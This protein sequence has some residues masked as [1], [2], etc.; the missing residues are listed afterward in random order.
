M[1]TTRV[2]A[3]V[4]VLTSLV[5]AVSLGGPALAQ[6]ADL[7][8]APDT[9]AQDKALVG[10]LNHRIHDSRIGSDFAMRVIDAETGR[11]IYAHDADNPQRAASNTKLV[12]AV[13]ALATA[14]P[15]KALTT[16]ARLAA[17]GKDVILQGGGDP[18]LSPSQIY[19]L[20]D[21]TAAKLKRG[22]K[23]VVHLDLD[24]FYKMRRG[25][26]WTPGYSN[27]LLAGVQA[28]A[29]YG[30]HPHYPAKVVASAFISRLRAK[31]INAVLGRT[32]SAVPKARVLAK[33]KGHTVA[34]SVAVMLS[35]SESNIAEVL[36]RQAAVAAGH[37]GSWNGGIATT[38]EVMKSLGVSMD[39]V[40]I[41]DGSGLSRKDHLT[42]R[43]LTEMLRAAKVLQGLRFKAMF[44]RYAMPIAGQTGTL[45]TPYGRYD[46]YP[47]RCAAGRV[48]AKT[49]TLYD[50]I[51]LSGVSKTVS[52]RTL[53]FSMIIN[54]RPSQYEKLANRRALDGLAATITG[55][56]K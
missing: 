22:S 31:G 35:R 5:L 55:C 36:F 18:L 24:L 42:P 56:W 13:T 54:S 52:G 49:G 17:N 40:A 8:T 25:P 3:G 38:K 33:T 7:P 19:S 30:Q 23:V 28:L 44:A 39:N 50:A 41:Y 48:Q 27:Y 51:A 37:R 26:G 4:A 46:T 16:Y 45:A 34:Q 9:A 20:A 43:F 6:P 29:F 14:G 32:E 10:L 15:N 21:R 2:R 47:S 53:V 12:V 1:T 11:E